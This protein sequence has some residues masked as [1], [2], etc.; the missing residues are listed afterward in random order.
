MF[1]I[2][3]HPP[4]KQKRRK[5]KASETEWDMKEWQQ[6]SV[7]KWKISRIEYGALS[8]KQHQQLET[9]FSIEK[10]VLRSEWGD[11]ARKRVGERE[12]EKERAR[13]PVAEDRAIGNY[14]WLEKW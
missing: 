5:I 4:V 1:D 12:R 2:V 13:N 11:I 9:V 8:Q 10:L 6:K 7:Q 3:T 14:V